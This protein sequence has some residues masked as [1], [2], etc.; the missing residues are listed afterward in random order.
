VKILFISRK[1]PPSIGGMQ[2]LSYQLV[3]RARR[4][5][6]V[7]QITWGGSQ[8]FLPLFV[9]FALVNGIRLARRGVDLVHI[10]DP[11]LSPLGWLLSQLCRVPVVVTAHG[12]DV[13]YPSRLYQ[14]VVPGFFLPRLERIVCISESTRQACLDRGIPA[15]KLVVI[16]PGVEVPDV[17][18]PKDAARA[19]LSQRVGADLASVKVLLTVG[20]LVPRK[21]VVWFAEHVAPRL[22]GRGDIV[23]IVVGDGPDMGQLRRVVAQE[24]LDRV[25][26]PL[27]RV[28]A[29][30]LQQVYAAADL[31]LMPNLECAGDMEGFGL[32]ALEA[33]AYGVPVWASDLQGIRDAVLPGRIGRLIPPAD[34]DLWRAEIEDALSRPVTLRELGAQARAEAQRHFT[35]DHMVQDYI[36]LFRAIVAGES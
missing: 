33:A 16:R 14:K 36:S 18:P 35:W 25:V 21:G 29:E 10:G 32:V 19:W 6:D 23:Y 24:H 22:A 5:A 30:S 2:L 9:C 15:R 34:V 4:H 3:Q 17:L 11:V 7:Q 8:A 31:F 26:Y 20:R 1:H 27:G 13:T 12:L 28:D